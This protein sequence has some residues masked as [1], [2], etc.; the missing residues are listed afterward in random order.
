MF[1]LC[2]RAA[3]DDYFYFF[4]CQLFAT[5]VSQFSVAIHSEPPLTFLQFWSTSQQG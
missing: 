1:M 2:C 3:V 4:I 5:D